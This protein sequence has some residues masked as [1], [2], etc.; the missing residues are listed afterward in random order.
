MEGPAGTGDERLGALGG[1]ARS[2]LMP[3]WRPVRVSHVQAAAILLEPRQQ[4][5]RGDVGVGKHFGQT[6][7]RHLEVVVVQAIRSH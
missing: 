2:E 3:R 1:S 4:I 6:S 7:L 5:D